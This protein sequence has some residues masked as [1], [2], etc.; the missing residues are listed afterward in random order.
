MDG[1][2][3]LYYALGQLSYA[4]A[5]ADG[6][7]QKEETDKLHEI[8]QKASEHINSDYDIAEIVFTLQS[9]DHTSLEKSYEWAMEEIKL[10]KHYFKPQLRN[11]FYYI[12][13]AI[14]NS[15]DGVEK[16]EERLLDKIQNDIEDI[17]DKSQR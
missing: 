6:K 4:V 3:R 12:L 13:E 8:I 14:A 11:D 10:C 5:L 1:R 16:H 15:S 2:Q 17:F 9:R 7:I